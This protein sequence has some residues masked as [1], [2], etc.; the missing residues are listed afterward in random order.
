MAS[1]KKLSGLAE[2]QGRY[3]Q[4]LESLLRT[5]KVVDREPTTVFIGGGGGCGGAGGGYGGAMR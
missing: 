1:N 4:D 5:G 3:I 2:A